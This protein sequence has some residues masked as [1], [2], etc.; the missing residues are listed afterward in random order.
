MKVIYIYNVK[1]YKY[2]YKKA[3][4]SEIHNNYKRA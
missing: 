3:F 4:H 2:Y 1:N